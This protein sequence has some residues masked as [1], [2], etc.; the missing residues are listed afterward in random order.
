VFWCAFPTK[1]S[2]KTKSPGQHSF[3]SPCNA[4]GTQWIPNKIFDNK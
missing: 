3:P 2:V 1:S 4:P